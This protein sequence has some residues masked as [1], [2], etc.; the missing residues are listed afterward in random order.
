M[1]TR[2]RID[3]A[4][5]HHIINRGVNRSTVFND[6]ADKEMFLRIVNK[7]ALIHRVILHDYCLMNNHYHMLIETEKE[8]LSTFMR[9][10]SANYSQYFNK[11]HRRSGHLWQDRYQSKY[12][13]SEEY[14]YTLIRYIEYNPVKAALTKKVGEYPYTLS[15]SIFSAKEH[16]PCSNESLLVKSYDLESLAEF[17]E[18]PM[19][20]EELNYLE[21]KQKQKIKKTKDGIKISQSKEFEEHFT[22]IQNKKERNLAIINAYLD[23]YTQSSISKYLNLSKSLVS[24]V[25]KSGDVAPGV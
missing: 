1:P 6:S 15:S 14:L 16:L 3:L 11:R 2:P 10:V 4:G 25:I 13:T 22:D 17:L 23:G 19:S 20:E 7:A 9:I 24:K 18:K 8:N 5:Y 12:I 21:K